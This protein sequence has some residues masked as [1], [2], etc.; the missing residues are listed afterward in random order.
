MFGLEFHWS[1]L[2]YAHLKDFVAVWLYW[3]IFR[4]REKRK[5]DEYDQTLPVMCECSVGSTCRDGLKAWASA[6]IL[7][8]VTI[9]TWTVKKQPWSER[10]SNDSHVYLHALTCDTCWRILQ[11][12]AQSP[13]PTAPTSPATSAAGWRRRHPWPAHGNNHNNRKHSRWRFTRYK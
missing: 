13:P 1:T 7:F 2:K 4:C 6:V 12:S 3:R 5:D 9:F 8:A 10:M 11:P